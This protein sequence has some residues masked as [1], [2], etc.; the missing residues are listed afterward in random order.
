MLHMALPSYS[1]GPTVCPL[2]QEVGEALVSPPYRIN[3]PGLFADLSTG[4]AQCN[5]W[6]ESQMCRLGMWC[7]AG[8]AARVGQVCTLATELPKVGHFLHVQHSS[9]FPH[10]APAIAARGR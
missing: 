5:F 1:S 4:D 7:T 9:C 10:M 3:P 6:K 8:P 2:P